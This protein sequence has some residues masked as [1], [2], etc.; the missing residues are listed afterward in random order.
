MSQVRYVLV[1][2]SGPDVLTLAPVH[3][4]A[5]SVQVQDFADRG[6]LLAVGTFEQPEVNGAMAILVSREA[7]EEFAAKDPFVVHGVVSRYRVHAWT[8]VLA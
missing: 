4:A 7:A 3:Y 8:D 1:Y 5:H 2:D 6:L